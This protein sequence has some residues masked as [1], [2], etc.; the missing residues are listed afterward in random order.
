MLEK[1]KINEKEVGVGQYL[2][3]VFC[4]K[5]SLPKLGI[6]RE[7]AQVSLNAKRPFKDSEMII[8]HSVRTTIRRT[9]AR[10]AMT[11]STVRLRASATLTPLAP[12]VSS[13]PNS[14]LQV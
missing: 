13:I 8:L 5:L 14:A 12:T 4:M 10:S 11:A 3:K 2:K 6:K 7:V 1:T 9:A